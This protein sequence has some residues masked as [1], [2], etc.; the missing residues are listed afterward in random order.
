[1]RD[2]K[3]FENDEII[4][5]WTGY[6][7]TEFQAYDILRQSVAPSHKNFRL[8]PMEIVR[9]VDELMDRLAI[10]MNCQEMREENNQKD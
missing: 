8:T 2:W 7:Q 5:I 4:T 1:M 10:K 3:K 6:L 9:L